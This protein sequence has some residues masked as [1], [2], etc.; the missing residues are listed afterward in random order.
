MQAAPMF[1][2]VK[3]GGE[4]LYRAA[5][6]GRHVERPP[7]LQF[8]EKFRVWREDESSPDGHYEIVCSKG[9]YVRSLI[10]DLVRSW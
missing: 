4:K 1:S 9:T 3:I 6:E 7:R 10:H 2:A 5:R 8:V